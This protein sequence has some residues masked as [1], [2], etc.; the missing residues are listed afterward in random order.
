MWIQKNSEHIKYP[1]RMNPNTTNG[2]DKNKFYRFH[3]GYNYT[4]YECQ[5]LK[6]KIEKLVKKGVLNRFTRRSEDERAKG[7]KSLRDE[8]KKRRQASGEI[9]IMATEALSRH[10]ISFE[11]E[12]DKVSTPHF[13]PL[14]T[15][16]RTNKFIMKRI[17][18]DTGSSINLITLEVFDKLRLDKKKNLSRVLYSLVGLDGK[19]LP[20]IGVTNLTVSIF[21]WPIL[22]NHGPEQT[23]SP[24]PV[25]EVTIV[26]LKEKKVRLA[27]AL[28]GEN[29]CKVLETLKS[30]IPT[31]ARKPEDIT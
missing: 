17:L 30:R 11:S 9:N 28:E 25:D 12:T 23:M 16:A 2:K 29:Q 1:R 26:E 6:D 19:S 5:N 15:S 13:D 7:P 22:N 4:K 27:S 14:V 8:R 21:G 10:P 18:I 24:Q 20:V 3:D 31:F